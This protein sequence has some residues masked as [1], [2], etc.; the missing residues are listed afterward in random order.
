M[1]VELGDPGKQ[2]GPAGGRLWLQAESGF[3]PK[4]D[5]RTSRVKEEIPYCPLESEKSENKGFAEAK[6]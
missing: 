2:R 1:P 6:R 4:C 3:C 5:W